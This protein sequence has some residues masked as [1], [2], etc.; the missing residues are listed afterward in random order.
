MAA[1][2]GRYSIA[3]GT[4]ASGGVW[5]PDGLVVMDLEEWRWGAGNRRGGYGRVYSVR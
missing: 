3:V 4:P 1:T 2:A 5:H